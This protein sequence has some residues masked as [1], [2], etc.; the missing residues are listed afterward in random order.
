M[1]RATPS[2]TG[3]TSLNAP[4]TAA[5]RIIDGNNRAP[6]AASVWPYST[7]VAVF[8]PVAMRSPASF[9]S[10]R[11]MSSRSVPCVFRPF[12]RSGRQNRA[13]AKLSQTPRTSAVSH[14][15]RRNR[16]CW[17]TSLS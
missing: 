5:S 15:F 11:P 13:A 9:V 6:T 2:R 14:C 17:K 7:R 3:R 16:D 10:Q 1:I 4:E 8:R 12:G